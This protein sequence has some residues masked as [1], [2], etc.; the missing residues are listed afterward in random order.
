M[1]AWHTNTHIQP[2][3]YMTLGL[4]THSHS[5]RAN[6]GKYAREMAEHLIGD[7]KFTCRCL[8]VSQWYNAS[9]NDCNHPPCL[10][11]FP[12]WSF[13][14]GTGGT[15]KGR[16]VGRGHVTG[17][18]LRSVSE[19]RKSFVTPLWF[20]NRGD[21][22]DLPLSAVGHPFCLFV[23]SNSLFTP[24]SLS[25]LISLNSLC[26]YLIYLHTTYTFA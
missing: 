26:W 5:F 3:S 11:S 7:S 25:P 13:C 1:W 4:H 2:Y 12:P 6:I 18:R 19:G 16:E 23:S 21:G 22:Q 24:F 9:C 10:F 17:R 14:F 15:L 20:T 8:N